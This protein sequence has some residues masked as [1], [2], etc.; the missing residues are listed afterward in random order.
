VTVRRPLA[1]LLLL[2]L[3]TACDDPSAP[4]AG[5]ELAGGETTVFDATPNAFSLSARNMSFERRQ[6]FVVGNSFFNKNWVTAPASTAARDGLGPTFNARSCSACHFKDGRGRPPRDGEQFAG[7]LLRLSVPGEDVHGGP[8]GV[9]GYGDQLQPFGIE[10]VAGEAV[11]KVT[12]VER[13]GMFADGEPYS[14]RVPT[15]TF[16][17]LAHGPLP[18][19]L[20]VSP[21][22]APAMIGLGLLAAIPEADILAREDPD[23]A[24]GDGI[25]GRANRVWDVAAGALALGRFG[26]KANQPDV[27]QQT[28]GAFLGD[29]GLTTALFPTENCPEGQVDCA[30]APTGGAPEVADDLLSDIVLYS[31][32]LAVPARRDVAEKAVLRGRELF[33]ELGCADCHVPRHVTAAGAEPLEAAG[34]TIFPY[35]DLLLHD[36]GEA[37]ADGRPDFAADGRE[38]RTPP[39]W[40]IGLVHTVNGHTEFLHDGRARSLMEAV[41]WHGG[42]AEAAQ[43]AALALPRDDRDALVRFLESL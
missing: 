30:A 31:A 28:A 1:Y 36:M 12:Y 23:D 27:H 25:S 21:R 5:E 9:P 29:M 22:V 10:G 20:L 32:T 39:L 34:Q 19:D 24:D 8:L 33:R 38:W 15:Y 41:L 11:P 42:E 40:G 37:L 4:E 18:P 2:S 6:R 13:P 7:L 26:W 16:D 35:T 3:G 43:K 17:Q 14:L